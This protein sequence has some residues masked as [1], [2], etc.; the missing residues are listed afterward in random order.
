MHSVLLAITVAVLGTP[1]LGQ[2]PGD[3]PPL[4]AGA[5]NT[6]LIN[7]DTLKQLPAHSVTNNTKWEAGVLPT[8]C[9][10]DPYFYEPRLLWADFEARNIRYSDCDKGSWAICRHKNAAES[11]SEITQVRPT[12]SSDMPTTAML[13]SAR[14]YPGFPSACARTSPTSS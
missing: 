13:T 5:W 2:N 11:W 6:D 9:W 7:A 10:N 1:A 3:K 12:S 4:P 8:A 14:L